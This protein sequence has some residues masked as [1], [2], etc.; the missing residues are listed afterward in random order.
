MPTA[1]TYPG[2][3][4]E[5]IPGG[6]RPIVG[7]STST[8]AF[9]GFFGKG[10]LDRPRTISSFEDFNRHYGGLDTRSEA[11]YAIRQYFT[12][13]GQTAVVLRVVEPNSAETATIDFEVTIG[14]N[15]Q[16]IITVDALNEGD[17]GEE[18]QVGIEHVG[19]DVFNLVV[20]RVREVDGQDRVVA[21]EVHL[22]L[23]MQED[24]RR[25]VQSTVNASSQLVRVVDAGFQAG[26]NG[27]T[28]PGETGTGLATAAVLNDVAL[29]TE[30]V[31]LQNG[32][33]GNFP[34][35][36]EIGAAL[37][38]LDLIA[39]AFYSMLCI[40]SMFAMT[41]GT[42]FADLTAAANAHCTDRRVF[43]FIDPNV[44]ADTIDQALGFNLTVGERNNAIYFPR[45]EIGD[46][47]ADGA[48]RI[49]APSGTMAGIYARTDTERGVWKAPAGTSARIRGANIAGDPM[50]EANSGQL[51][52]LGINVLRS[53]PV[54]GNVVW[55]SRTGDGA[56]QRASEWK[57]VPVRRMALYIEESLSQGLQ[58]VVFEPNADP[59]WAQIRLSVGGFMQTLF[60]KG[61]FQGSTPKEAYLV[62]CDSST[63]TQADIDAGVVN[64]LVGFAPLKPAEFVVIQLQQITAS[65]V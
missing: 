53:M 60:R 51:N 59:L 15:D 31:A 44:T 63:T 24:A 43:L 9:V 30:F 22:N 37:P 34:S 19:A 16:T 56:D 38:T 57:Y 3:Y 2:V 55:G 42:D 33:D 58:W 61:A 40:P 23:S 7:V 32:D 39:P 1:L 48:P 64:I 35:G 5:E 17:W 11:S 6:A 47:L 45:L 4:V 50:T 25:Y 62:R 28:R 20:R 18:V 41:T 54:F 10:P 21:T 26:V 49:V 52:P 8:T 29:T 27:R 46:P 13:G 12:N 14:P 65:A 36:A